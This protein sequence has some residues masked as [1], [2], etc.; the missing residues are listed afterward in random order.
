MTTN[1]RSM[2]FMCL[3]SMLAPAQL[4][5]VESYVDVTFAPVPDHYVRYTSGNTIY[6]EGLV[7]GRWV[8]RYWTPEGPINVPYELY[9]DNGFQI[10]AHHTSC[11]RGLE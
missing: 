9:A 7:D 4:I 3:L 2:L 5:S 6:V 11:S 1:G 8:G 10:G